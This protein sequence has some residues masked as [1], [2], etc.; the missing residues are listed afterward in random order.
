MKVERKTRHKMMEDKDAVIFDLD[1]SLR[2]H[3]DVAS[4]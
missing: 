2:F 1:G 4:D 3:V